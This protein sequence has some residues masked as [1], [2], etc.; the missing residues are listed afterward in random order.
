MTQRLS[1]SAL[2]Q[3]TKDQC[4]YTKMETEKKKRCQS[5]YCGVVISSPPYLL[6]NPIKA[7]AET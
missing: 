4:S 2:I 6:R 3:R 1:I 5:F 7:I